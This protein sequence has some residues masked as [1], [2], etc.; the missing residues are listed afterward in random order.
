MANKPE[1]DTSFLSRWWPVDRRDLHE[2]E[3]RLAA[4]IKRCCQAKWGFNI[5]ISHPQPKQK[6]DKTMIEIKIT[7]E[8]KVKVTLA[9]VTSTGKPAKLDGKPTWTVTSGASTVVVADDGLS[10]ELVSADSPETVE[11]LVEADADL[12][13]GVITISE[14]I[15]LVVSGANASSLGL[16]VGTPEPK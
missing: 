10:A 12:G 2:T 9:P 6:K 8:E 13:E 16:V 11:I 7:N 15:S 5:S 3:R 1:S 4:L 14:V